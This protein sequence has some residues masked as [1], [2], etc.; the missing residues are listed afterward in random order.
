MKLRDLEDVS[1]IFVTH[2]MNNVQYI[3]SEYAVVDEDGK[4]VF[5]REGERLCLI[6]SK[7]M[8][9]RQGKVIFSGTDES[10]R[11]AEDPYIHRFLRGH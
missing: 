4:V 10:L 1:S 6:N 8:M 3:C 5:E 11:K 9:M 2:E 7:V